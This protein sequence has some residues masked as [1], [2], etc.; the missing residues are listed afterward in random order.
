MNLLLGGLTRIAARHNKATGKMLRIFPSLRTTSCGVALG[1]PFF[2]FMTTLRQKIIDLASPLAAAQGLEIWG[3]EIGGKPPRN[4]RLF[5]DAPAGEGG[6]ATIEQCEEISRQLG[7][8]LEVEDC[9]PGPWNLEVSTPGLER[10]FF[11]LSQMR[12]YVGDMVEAALKAPLSAGPGQPARAMWRGRLVNVGEDAF[13]IEPCQIS[14]E[15]EI[16]PEKIPPVSIPW[17]GRKSIRRIHIFQTPAKP[18]KGRSK[19]GR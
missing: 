12:P 10:T 11:E 6:G 7:L 5:V 15:G 17:A 18:G 4:V 13:T 1:H 9:M 19:K 14:A 8:A 3:L 16:L 2:V